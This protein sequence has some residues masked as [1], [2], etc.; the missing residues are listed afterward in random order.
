MKHP[1]KV[2]PTAKDPPTT[3]D[4]QPRLG[5]SMTA[6]RTATSARIERA[7]PGGSSG[8]SSG[9][10]ELG[11]N[12]CARSTVIVQTGTLIRNT[13]GQPKFSTSNPPSNGP[14]EMPIPATP[15]QIP[16]ARAR[17]LGTWKVLVMMESVVG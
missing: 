6:N 10:L 12:Q 9:A 13:A 7:A 5:A 11:T 14:I 17:S 4:V 15:A 3:G 1:S 8:L 2:A 16:M